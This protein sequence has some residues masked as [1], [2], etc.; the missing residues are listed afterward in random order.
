MSYFFQ[1]H[2]RTTQDVD[3]ARAFYRHVL[4]E[5]IMQVVP[6]HE[7]AVARGARPHWLGS[8][9]VEDVDQTA[10]AFAARGATVLGPKWTA[11]D[12]STGLTLRDPGGAVLG[13]GTPAG[14]ALRTVTPEVLWF[15][16]N[17]DDVQ[18]AKRTYGELLGFSFGEAQPLGELG[19]LHPF[20][21]HAGGP[22]VGSMRD[23]ASHPGVHAHWLF[24]F[25]VHSLSAALEA[26]EAGGGDA[27]PIV[28]SP[29]GDQ[30]A[31]CHDPQGAAFV[32]RQAAG[33]R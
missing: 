22:T 28:S 11:P 6:L 10:A 7:Q 13:L 25:G 4:G 15:E 29:T 14:A 20:A 5:T 18:L 30:L 31:M 16:L 26:V 23:V 9:H 17:T 2:L 24:H 21:F 32:I 8:L 12:G 3:A 33:S 27:Q 19:T 1:L